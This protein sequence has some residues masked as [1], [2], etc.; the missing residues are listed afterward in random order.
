MPGLA[1][2][3]GPTCRPI[4]PLL[5]PQSGV[6]PSLPYSRISSVEMEKNTAV[7]FYEKNQR[8][9]C[10]V[11]RQDAFHEICIHLFR[12]ISVAGVAG[13][14]CWLDQAFNARPN[15]HA[16]SGTTCRLIQHLLRPQSGFLPSLPYSSISSVEMKKKHQ[17]IF[18][19][20]EQKGFRV[21]LYS[22]RLF[23]DTKTGA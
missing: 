3:S 12:I 10:N 9:P 21:C 17:C 13:P 4:Q 7:Y 20:S 5:R 1:A 14:W 8:L 11:L 2:I 18:M 6:L 23:L 19:G 15:L 16:I 22:R